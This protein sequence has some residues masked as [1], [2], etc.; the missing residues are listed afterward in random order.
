MSEFER[1]GIELQKEQILFKLQELDSKK[2]EALAIANPLKALVLER[3]TE[4]DDELDQMPVTQLMTWDAQD[5]TRTMLKLAGWRAKMEA[6][7]NSY[8]S[9]QTTTAVYRLP[10]PEHIAVTAAVERTKSSFADVAAVAEDQDLKRQLFSL[11]ISHRGEQI[12]WPVFGGEP[13]EDFFKFKKDF[14]DAA[15]QN[16]T[17]TKNQINKLRENLRGYAKSLVPSSLTNITR[18]LEILEHACGDSMRVVTHRV[19]TLM[20][21]GPWPAEGT[22]DCYTRQVKWIVKVQTLIQD[23][24][25]LANTEESL[26]DIIYNKEK[27]SQILKLFPT[28]IVDKLAKIP[29]YKEDK[30]KRIIAKLEDVR[31]VSQ[32][33]ELIYGS[34]GT[35]AAEPKKAVVEK[36]PT[37]HTNFP[38]P[39][40]F[41]DCR[42]CQVLDKQ[43]GASELFINHVSDYATGCPKFA[44]L[45]TDQR[46]VI[47]KEAN[48]CPKC[49]GKDVKNNFQH[50]K[51]CPIAT[52]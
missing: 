49:M 9:F 20:K 13:G 23:I 40:Q 10:E 50:K 14:L 21:V 8:Q 6:I 43:G 26:A 30:Y 32:N 7:S 37:G 12:K 31:Q 4:L 38:Q 42:V 15:K 36:V 44:S 1:A 46:L 25:E 51:D 45:G 35:S 16:K 2:V 11:D 27:L 48:L 17:S 5:D 34:G 39:R 18:G 19:D 3:C 22:K 33:R 52:K 29:G 28:F 47:A 24:L 41:P